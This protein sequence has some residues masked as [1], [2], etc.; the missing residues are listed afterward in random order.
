MRLGKE[1][2]IRLTCSLARISLT[3][4]LLACSLRAA[5]SDQANAPAPPVGSDLPMLGKSYFSTASLFLPEGALPNPVG[6]NPAA[7]LGLGDLG[8]SHYFEIDGGLHSLRGGLELRMG[9]LNWA[10]MLSLRTSVRIIYSGVNG[11]RAP[12]PA[13][14]LFQLSH[15][16]NGL[17]L[18]VAH[19]LSA[20]QAGAL[21][22]GVALLPYDQMDTAVFSIGQPVANSSA[23]SNFQGRLGVLWHNR[24]VR[25]GGVYSYERDSTRVSFPGAPAGSDLS[26]RFHQRLLT[27]GAALTPRLGTSLFYSRQRLRVNGPGLDNNSNIDYWGAEQFL[28]RQTVLRLARSG[29]GTALSIGYLSGSWQGFVS[30]ARRGFSSAEPYYGRGNTVFV[31]VAY[32]K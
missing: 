15:S 6:Y 16:G 1:G 10:Q 18:A 12:I 19:R 24:F 32:G 27:F 7:M 25:V 11:N 14:G 17:E 28:S 3:M 31:T 30:Y 29:G 9:I 8:Q 26:G 4:V 5:V 21:D 13:S 2:S 20:T 23:R 22:L